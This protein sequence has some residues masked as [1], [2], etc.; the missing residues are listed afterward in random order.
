VLDLELASKRRAATRRFAFKQRSHGGALGRA[1]PD[2]LGGR[3]TSTRKS[4]RGWGASARRPG[5]SHDSQ[6]SIRS[7]GRSLNL[8]EFPADFPTAADPLAKSLEIAQPSPN[9]VAVSKT[10][11][12]RT[13]FR[14]DWV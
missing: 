11:M 1:T 6:Q 7:R 5:R 13:G 8:T 10:G 9:P 14:G 4:K 12:S 2:R 3:A